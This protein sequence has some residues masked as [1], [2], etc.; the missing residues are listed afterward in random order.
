ML[1]KK[2]FKLL[3]IL[4][5]II[6]VLVFQNGWRLFGFKACINPNDISISKTS[7]I[8]N[9]IKISG[10]CDASYPYFNTY[11]Y[12]VKDNKMYIGLKYN[13]FNFFKKS[14][15][16]NIEIPID[17]ASVEK[18]YIKGKNSIKEIWSK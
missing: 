7:F 1:Q 6:I 3:I 16:F 10:V 8:D 2:S 11:I 17:T 18:I 12:K 14:G 9:K 13:S 4:F 15:A 5:C